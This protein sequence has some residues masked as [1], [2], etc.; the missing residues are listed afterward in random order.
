MAHYQ[1]HLLVVSV[2]MK[3]ALSIS[4][5]CDFKHGRQAKHGA[6]YFVYI[7]LFSTNL[8]KVDIIELSQGDTEALSDKDTWP[9][10]SIHLLS[11]V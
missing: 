10:S 9:G 8:A 5:D 11:A 6:G 3:Q 2:T 1:Y 7:I 4:R